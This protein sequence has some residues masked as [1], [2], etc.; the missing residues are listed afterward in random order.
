MQTA[1]ELTHVHRNATLAEGLLTAREAIAAL[2]DE[3]ICVLFAHFVAGHR[4]TLIV[5]R[6][7]DGVVSVIKRRH[8]NGMGGVCTVRATQWHGCQLECMQDEKPEAARVKACGRALEVV[9]G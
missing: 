9:R 8:P 1:T 3:G 2:N 4:P 6:L 5:D 7:P